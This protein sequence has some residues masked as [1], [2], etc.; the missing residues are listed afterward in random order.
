MKIKVISSNNAVTF[1][2]KLQEAADNGYC[3]SGNL[4]VTQLNNGLQLFTQLMV[5]KDKVAPF[6]TKLW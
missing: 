5:K 4:Q 1:E 2:A 3:F 6:E